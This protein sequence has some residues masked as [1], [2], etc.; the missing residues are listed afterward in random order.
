MK[1]YDLRVV[2]AKFILIVTVSTMVTGLITL[3]KIYYMRGDYGTVIFLSTFALL[4]IPV[5][6]LLVIADE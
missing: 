6:A 2:I 3:I 5:W 1:W 4:P